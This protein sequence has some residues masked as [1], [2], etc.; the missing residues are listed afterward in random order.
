M[1][2]GGPLVLAWEHAPMCDAQMFED[3]VPCRIEE[4]PG[5]RFTTPLDI[6]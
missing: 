6:T 5:S 4:S 2:V 1:S 3:P